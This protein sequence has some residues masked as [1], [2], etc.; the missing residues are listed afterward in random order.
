MGLAL[1]P[2]TLLARAGSTHGSEHHVQGHGDAEVQGVVVHHADGEEH[3][4]H[5]GIVPATQRGQHVVTQKTP[6]GEN[7]L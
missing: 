6:F 5:D 3:G 1:T 4:D 2:Q 7:Q